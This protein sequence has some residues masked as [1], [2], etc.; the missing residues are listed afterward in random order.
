MSRMTSSSRFWRE[1]SSTRRSI[2][3]RLR[4]TKDARTTGK[5]PSSIPATPYGV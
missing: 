1:T 3:E 5:K 4:M 2:D